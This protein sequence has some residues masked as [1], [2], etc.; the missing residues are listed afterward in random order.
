MVHDNGEYMV[1][2]SACRPHLWDNL[3]PGRCSAIFLWPYMVDCV[4]IGTDCS[5]CTSCDVWDLLLRWMKQTQNG[6]KEYADYGRLGM[7]VQNK[8][9]YDLADRIEI[10]SF[11]IAGTHN[12]P[13]FLPRFKITIDRR[14]FVMNCHVLSFY[15]GNNEIWIIFKCNIIFLIYTKN[16]F[17]IYYI[18]E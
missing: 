16:M 3:I 17:N 10:N 15:S 14:Y 7:P 12:I 9:E 6:G 1:G 4:N 11:T 13:G 18:I 8:F 5:S 2:P